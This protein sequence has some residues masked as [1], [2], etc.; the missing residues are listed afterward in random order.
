MSVALRQDTI[1]RSDDGPSK[2]RTVG[3]AT[4][5]RIVSKDFASLLLLAGFILLAYHLPIYYLEHRLIPGPLIGTNMTATDD[6]FSPPEF[7]YPLVREPISTLW[8][9][10]VVVFVPLFIIAAFQIKLRSLWDFHAGLTGLLR[11]VGSTYDLPP[12]LP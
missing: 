9:G 12:K 10:L 2:A 3:L 11:T 5:W 6:G 8:C 1:L 4:Y 7:S